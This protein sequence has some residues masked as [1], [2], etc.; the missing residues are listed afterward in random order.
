MIKL[1]TG[2]RLNNKSSVSPKSLS[3][4]DNSFE[5]ENLNY[6]LRDD[7]DELFETLLGYFGFY[8]YLKNTYISFIKIEKKY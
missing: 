4:N 3:T 5:K 1:S 8:N 2:K 6:K 7:P